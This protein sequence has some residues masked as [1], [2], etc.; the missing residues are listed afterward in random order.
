MSAPPP[1]PPP[2]LGEHGIDAGPTSPRGDPLAAPASRVAARVLDGLILSLITFPIAY[3]VVGDDDAAGFGG[4]GSDA[5]FVELYLL[6]VLGVA[7]GFVYDAV[8]T[9]LYGGSP[10]KLVFGMRV[11]RADNGGPAEWSHAIVRWS[12]PGAFA[13]IPIPIARGLLTVVVVAVSLAYI[14]T[15][16]LRQAVWDQVAKTLV[17]KPVR[18][19]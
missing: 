2:P 19:T 5:D 12:I 14:F 11:V 15:K 10:M 17:V 13:L 9:K 3:A 6:A 16:P 7:I 4:F 18:P 8:M 1:P